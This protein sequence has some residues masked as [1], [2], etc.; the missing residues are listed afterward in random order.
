MFKEILHNI[1]KHAR[2][3][4]VRILVKVSSNQFRLSVEDDGAGFDE[5]QVR[6]GNGLKNLRRRAADLRGELQ[7][8][9][10]PGRGSRFTVT[11]SIT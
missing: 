10:Q 7:I 6:R 3:T 5:S 1:A 11:A 8:Q 4:R 9:S 2:A